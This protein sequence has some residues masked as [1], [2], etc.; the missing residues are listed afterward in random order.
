MVHFLPSKFKWIQQPRE[1]IKSEIVFLQI[2][3]SEPELLCIAI[4]TVYCLSWCSVMKY[5]DRYTNNFEGLL[6]RGLREN[7]IFIS[8]WFFQPSFTL[9]LLIIL[10]FRSFSP[11]SRPLSFHFLRAFFSFTRHFLSL[12]AHLL[13]ALGLRPF[14]NNKCH[15]I[16]T[17]AILVHTK[18]SDA[19]NRK[20]EN[21]FVF[22]VGE[23]STQ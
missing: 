8:G 13:S 21:S 18:L 1:L 10:S 9:S 23:N 5:I 22:F 11:S 7:F 19:N 16:Q 6:V 3:R 4:F 17:Q 20:Q 2:C 12:A 15:K 14:S